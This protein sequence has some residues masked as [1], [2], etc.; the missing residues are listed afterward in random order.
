MNESHGNRQLA[1]LNP[2]T[3]LKVS[4]STMHCN[5]ADH[6]PV[7]L[8]FPAFFFLPQEVSIYS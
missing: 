5:C 2:S 8:F 6:D 4:Y 1:S 3:W 7:A